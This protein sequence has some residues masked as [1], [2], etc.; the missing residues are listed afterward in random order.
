MDPSIRRVTGI[1]GI[2]FTVLT[3][4]VVILS[5]ESDFS[6]TDADLQRFFVDSTQQGLAFAA[7]VILPFAVAALLWFVAGIR[8]LLRA[9]DRPASALPAA[10]ALGGGVFA[11]TF[12]IGMTTT[13]AVFTALTFTDSYQFDAGVARLTLILGTVLTTGAL[14]GAAVLVVAT[15]MAGGRSGLLPRW[16]ARSGYVVAVLMLFSVLLFAWPYALFGLWLLTLSIM[17]LRTAKVTGKAVP[18]QRG[19]EAPAPPRTAG[20]GVAS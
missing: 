4:V 9:D 11:A 1:S 12:L 16:F 7:V 17:L 8:S 6:A 2:V 5:G 15:S 3:V 18:G 14:S 20:P 10:A 13:N 19:Q